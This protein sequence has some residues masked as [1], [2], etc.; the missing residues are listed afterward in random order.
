M[1]RGNTGGRSRNDV[2]A[3]RGSQHGEVNRERA[4]SV[5]EEQAI[6]GS[7]EKSGNTDRGKPDEVETGDTT[8]GDEME[9]VGEEVEEVMGRVI[10]AA[11]PRQITVPWILR[12][13]G[14]VTT[15]AIQWLIDTGSQRTFLSYKIYKQHLKGKVKLTSAKNIIMTA[16]NGSNVKV[17]GK[18]IAE[19]CLNNEWYQH[20]FV[21]A[22]IED[23]GIL[24]HD[25]LQE[26]RVR[27]DW[28]QHVLE[29][30]GN[31]LRCVYERPDRHPSVRVKIPQTVTIPARSD[32]IV[33]GKLHG[34]K[35]AKV[36]LV[37]AL[38]SFSRK[39]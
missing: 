19:V 15:P 16:A 13:E 35:H 1:N 33:N 32:I 37:S 17:T 22:Q 18:C 30:D 11:S 7:E 5:T 29:I 26:Y 36:G 25:L 14:R 23:E 34:K 24:G 2:T 20:E 9:E 6:T 3:G 12:M 21:V 4:A 27:W 8:S 28:D 31:D 10:S 39:T 38:K